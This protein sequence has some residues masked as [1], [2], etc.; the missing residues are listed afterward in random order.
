[1][2]D[3]KFYIK[4]V[5]SAL[6]LLVAIIIGLLGVCG[7]KINVSEI[8]INNLIFSIGSFIAILIEVIPFIKDFIKTKSLPKILNVVKTVVDAVEELKNLKGSE[9][10]EKATDIIVKELHKQGIKV[11]LKS[12]DGLIETAV[13]MRNQVVK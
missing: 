10:K 11:E 13:A 9:K 7:I 4:H 1:M 3:I 5:C 2:N 12:I 6:T 8:E